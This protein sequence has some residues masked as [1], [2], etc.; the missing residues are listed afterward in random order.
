MLNI[1]AIEQAI[2]DL[3]SQEVPNIRAAAKK[4]NVVHSTLLRRFNKQTVSRSEGQSSS[5]MLLTNAQ[6]LALTK[7]LN[8]LSARGLYPTPQ[9]ARKSCR[10][11]RGTL[12]RRAMD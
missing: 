2:S 12:C 1:E 5:N 3:N 6:E 7:Y 8:K 11:D 4:Y 9:N 10:G